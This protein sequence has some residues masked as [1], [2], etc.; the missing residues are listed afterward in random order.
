[1]FFPILVF[2]VAI[3]IASIAAWFSVVGLMAI[4]A[5]SAI[6][7]AIMAGSLEVGKLVTASWVYRNWKRA[8]FLLKSYLTFATIVLMFIT[9][10]GIFG[11]LSRAH[12]EQAAEGQQSSARVERIQNDITRFEDTI[13]RTEIKIE[14]LENESQE[15]T[16][17]L[18]SQIDKEQERMDKA[19]E[20]VQPAIDEQLAIINNEERGAEDQ[21]QSYLDQLAA[22]DNT[23][24]LLQ[25]YVAN[26]EIKKLQAL[27]GAK[28]DGN[29]GSRTAAKVEE[30]RTEQQ[31]EKERLVA[32]IEDIRTSV[33]N[34]VVEQ[35]R[36]EI[37]RLRNQANENIQ[38]SQQTIDRLRGQLNSVAEVDN[39]VEI[40]EL[41]EK[42]RSAETSIDEM[43]NEKFELETEIRKLEAEVGPIKYIAEVVYGDAERDTIDDAVRWLIIVFIFVFDPLAVLLLIAANYSFVN[44]NNFDGPQEE[45][46]DALFSKKKDNEEEKTLDNEPEISDNIEHNVTVENTDEADVKAGNKEYILKENASKE[47][48]IEDMIKSASPEALQI[49][50]RELEREINTRK[51]KG[52]GWLDDL[53]K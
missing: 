50:E 2:V 16:S 8:P 30:F 35:A 25:D 1:M 53:N 34:S 40:E 38:K 27:V 31:A 20:R 3:A 41:I 48:S 13:A 29:Y 52:S 32:I 28:A 51:E 43:L 24:S 18:Q 37:K 5:A 22:V 7:V 12:L 23:I 49:V 33:D 46:F 36:E 17:D 44:R 47:V 10:L 14:K 9:S 11:F 26:D 45:I 39:T 4:F 6:P 42:V 15:D 19:F 21:V